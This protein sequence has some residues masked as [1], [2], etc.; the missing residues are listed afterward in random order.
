M[1]WVNQIETEDGIL[2]LWELNNT[3]DELLAQFHFS[4]T[5]KDVFNKMLIEKRKKEFLSVRL[6]TERLLHSKPE[7]EYNT[8]GRPALKNSSLNI[9]IT[10]SNELVAV[11]LSEKKIGIDAENL[12]RNIENIA[13]RFLSEKEMEFA[14]KQE[15]TRT[16]MT[17]FWSAKEAVYKCS[18]E[19]GILFNREI[20]IATG[21]V[22]SNNYFYTKLVKDEKNRWF[23]CRAIF[24]KNNVVVYCVEEE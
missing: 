13:R 20:R 18:G 14:K 1:A 2:G 3:L 5:E 24:F 22:Q 19:T 15:N 8:A 17:L 10:H 9:S 23:K 16:T 21:D 4:A 6:L 12:N 11:Y 7:I